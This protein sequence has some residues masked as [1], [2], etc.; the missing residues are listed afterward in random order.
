MEEK[1]KK[2]LEELKQA[3]AHLKGNNNTPSRRVLNGKINVLLEL[4]KPTLLNK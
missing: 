1:I 3:K 4:L 2:K